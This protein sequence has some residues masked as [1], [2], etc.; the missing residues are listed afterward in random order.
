M[1][2]SRIIWVALLSVLLAVSLTAC[3]GGATTTAPSVPTGVTATAGDGQA[4][5]SWSS[6]T[7]VR[8]LI[9]STGQRHPALQRQMAQ[10]SPVPQARIVIRD[11]QMV[12]LIIMW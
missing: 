4:T 6:V 5:I 10:R 1:K 7:E 12:R 11:S 2:T 9:T 3:G 8:H